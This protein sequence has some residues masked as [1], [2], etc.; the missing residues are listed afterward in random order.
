MA[1]SGDRRMSSMPTESGKPVTLAVA[2]SIDTRVIVPGT[3]LLLARIRVS[4]KMAR[5][6]GV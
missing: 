6:Q 2:P 3:V 4:G 1:K 5:A